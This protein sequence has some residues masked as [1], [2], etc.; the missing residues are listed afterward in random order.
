MSCSSL[1]ESEY[2]EEELEIGALV[3]G[4]DEGSPKTSFQDSESSTSS[5]SDPEEGQTKKRNRP[6]R[7]KAR[8]VAANVR[9]RKR[10]MDY[11]QAFN[12]L[13]VALNHD[14]SGKRL[15][16]IATL[17]RAINRISALSVFLSTNPPSKP[18]THRECNGSS[19][20]LAAMAGSQLE[21]TRG[22][23]PRLEHQNYASWHAS[24]SHQMQSQEPPH[25]HRQ[26]A[27]SRVY[28]DNGVSSCPP[29]PHYP[30]YPTEGQLYASRGHCGGPHDHPPSPLRYSQMG[31]GLGYQ[32][33]MW[34]SCSQGY[35]DTFVEPS[36]ALG[37]PWQMNY[38]QEH[39]HSLYSSTDI[40]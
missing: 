8:R 38:L 9:E 2:S 17:Q 27:D 3:Q 26:P 29:S 13:R 36:P 22:R 20:G 37:H 7:S 34:G 21:P 18:C 15:S 11:N 19:V 40:L 4:K 25:M 23:V 30:C 32:S 24:I 6:V 14:L 12:A 39:E 31:D 10:I 16:K 5:P 1:A 28:M 35:I 33:T